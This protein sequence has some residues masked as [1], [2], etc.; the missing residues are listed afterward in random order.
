[1]MMKSFRSRIIFDVLFV[2]VLIGAAYLRLMG[3]NWDQSQ[4]LH[5]DERFLTMVSTALQPV[6]SVS[7]YFDTANSTLN[8]HNRGYGFY[9]YGTLPVFI[10][11][12]AAE[13]MSQGAVQAAQYL[14]TYGEDGL[15]SPLMKV[16]AATI[17]WAGY[18]EITLVGRVFAALSDVGSI[19]FLYLIATQLYGRKVGVLAAAFSALA[20]MQIQ[21][22]HF[23]VVDSFANFFIFMATFFAVQVMM[24]KND[25]PLRF[26]LSERLDLTN[27]KML[28]RLVFSPLVLQVAG[29][30]IALGAAVASKLNAAP[31]AIL[32]PGALLVRY[33]MTADE[34]TDEEADKRMLVADG[35]ADEATDEKADKRMLVTDGATDEEADKR[36][37]VTDGAADRATDE[38]ADKRM[39]VVNFES[40]RIKRTNTR[41]SLEVSLILL[42]LG[43]FFSVLAFRIFQ[44]YAFS[45]PGF[46]GIT[47]NPQWVQ[48]IADQRAQA[49]G[50][51]DFP[52]AL[53]WARRPIWFS[54]YNILAWGLGWSLGLLAVAGFL[55]MGWQILR[56]QGKMDVLL[57][58]WVA[59]YFVWQSLQWNPTMRYQLPIYP[60]LALFAAWFV[61]Y[62]PRIS[63]Q[64]F[65]LAN[66]KVSVSN[67]VYAVLTVVVLCGTAAWTYA[68]TRI[69]TREHS[70]VQ[71]TRWIYQ[72]VPG[73]LNLRISQADGS[74]YNQ[75]LPLSYN[76]VFSPQQ[77]YDTAFMAAAS[78]DMKQMVL[79]YAVD[80][81]QNG[82][83]TLTAQVASDFSFGAE[84]ILGT[85]TLTA[86]FG[87]RRN[88]KGESY[89]LN[90]DRPVTLDKNRT[91]YLRLVSSTLLTI[92]GASPVH[93][94]SWDDG[95][96]L[97]MDGYD[98]YGGIYQ[99]GLNFEMYWDDNQ[100]KLDRFVGNLES[101]DYI[102]ITSN[103]QW[104]TTT[105][106]P[107]R[108][109]LTTAFYRAL[110]G[111]P[112][113]QEVI[114]CYNVAEPGMF[115]GQLGYELVKTF[116]SYPEIFGYQINTQF[117]E[118]AFTVYDA[119]KVLIFKKTE[120][121]DTA[122]VRAILEK[123]DLSK[124]VRITPRQASRYPGDLTLSPGHAAR[125]REGG[126]WSDL[127]SYE[128]PQNAFPL[129]G[130]VLWYLTI[131]L[132]GLFTWPLLRLFLPGLPD[133]GYPL[134]RLVGL[135]LLAWFA[136]MVGSLGGEYSRETI[137]AGYGLIVALGAAAFWKQKDV[138]IAEWRENRQYFLLVEILFLAFFVIDFGIRLG[139]PDLWHPG[140]G[141]ERPMDFSYLN[142]I[143]KSV[144]FPPYDPWYAG[145]YINYYY[146]GFVLVGTPIKLL[147]I[148]PSIA[149]NFVLPTL[150]AMLAMGGFSVAWNLVSR[151][152]YQETKGLGKDV[153]SVQ[154]LAGLAAGA[155][156]V[157]VGN[158]GTVR[159]IYQALQKMV[160][161][162]AVMEDPSVSVFQHLLWAI[163]GLGKLLSGEGLPIGWGE[164]Y[165]A[166]SR[167]MPVGDLA[168]T[169]FPLFTFIYSDL[170]AHM[171]ALPLTVL[172]VS[173]ALST[174][175]AR[176]LNRWQWLATLAFGGLVIGALR[177]TNT[178]DFPTYLALGAIVAGYSVLLHVDVGEKPRL[179]L[180]PF[181]QRVL[182]ALGVMVVLAGFAFVLYQPFAR[183]YG[184]GY[185]SLEQWKNEKTPLGSYLTHWG[186]FLFVIV[187]WMAWETRQWMA[188]TPVS[189][190]AKLK[191]YTLLIEIALALLV[192]LTLVLQFFFKV[193]VAWLAFPVAA[194]ALLLLL[195][196]GQPDVKRLVLFMVGTGLVLT[197]AVEV[198]VLVGDIGRMNTVFKFYLQVWVLFAVSAAAAFGWILQEIDEWSV[199]WR[200]F[201]YTTLTLLF[202]GALLYLF[203]G[204]MDKLRDRMSAETPF[205][206]DSMEFMRF[207]TYWDQQEM[208]LREDYEAIRWMQDNIKGTPVI[209]EANT[210]EYRWGTRYTIYT[211]LPGVIG[212]NWHQRQQRA[213]FPPN[214]V[215]DRVDAV[216]FFYETTSGEYA[217][218]FL[219]KYNVEYIVVGQLE[220]IYH[221]NGIEKFERL[222]GVLWKKIYENGQTAI[223][224]VIR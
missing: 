165:W 154:L 65:K 60:L 152:R 150:F 183:W 30:G 133:R 217:R 79:G 189:A 110:I 53:Q 29:F 78:G 18:D 72:N 66:H 46:L 182:L 221:P 187:S 14:V 147:G 145:G 109:P 55:Y 119:P 10:V 202:A 186:L 94:T 107:E 121:Y 44:P 157:L 176:H 220:R 142:A 222:S 199:N 203:T 149:Y 140:R 174:L 57:W 117:A 13:W 192:L 132:L 101:G 74:V 54:G 153:F 89:T 128:W 90:F 100:E 35:A 120:A 38:E 178:W 7:E 11:R 48:N 103:R 195:R 39:M 124:V 197:L 27:W 113:E 28:G 211:G 80:F 144:A 82:I 112:P 50:D 190:L 19:V 77:P 51:V 16:L 134:S 168:I 62:G 209:V 105:R 177:P 52:P 200:N 37:L 34:A 188:Q 160:V 8:P 173:W 115:Q 6:R 158:L 47:P 26:T 210:P 201:W 118:E 193:Q 22:A 172:A 93:E 155:G 102:F 205:T 141:G 218:E 181:V 9:V 76:Y 4:H 24:G 167:V 1:M 58:G 31:L 91:Y 69:Y 108:Y 214:W 40:Y 86:D 137:A 163:Q 41:L 43:A 216:R 191:P 143:L 12:Y 161:P 97:R 42:I 99:G 219:A 180:S 56:G 70:R 116:T 129:L 71:A 20:V 49:S 151:V 166:P 215:T 204:T 136:W 185:S 36:M 171:I 75:P 122:T 208:T 111:C 45:G 81:T 198:I 146:W 135:L 196:P 59:F 156:L 63:N 123:V 96:P 67:L 164:W 61:F 138:L 184:L 131:G 169:E 23:Y 25:V 17:N 224:E 73:P 127:F 125:Q 126:T 106:V 207:S 92:S 64:E 85:A 148:V 2:L 114:W 98:A 87:P 84:T 175:L 33:W 88:P 32:L 68:F 104:A 194:W 206:F 179:G 21:Q 3:L 139:N 83:Q 223:Y 95:L 212:W 5:P 170:H 213:L 130:L 15:F 159:L 162:N